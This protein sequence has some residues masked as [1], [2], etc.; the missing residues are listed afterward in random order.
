MS[1]SLDGTLRE[2]VIPQENNP[3]LNLYIDFFFFFLLSWI[4]IGQ[5]SISIINTCTISLDDDSQHFFSAV[6]LQ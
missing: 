5:E 3:P 6:Y 2:S 1:P 4:S